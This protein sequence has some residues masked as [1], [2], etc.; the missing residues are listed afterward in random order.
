MRKPSS[1]TT[2]MDCIRVELAPARSSAPLRRA[3]SAVVPTHRAWARISKIMRGWPVMP[4]AAMASEP[5]VPT[6]MVSTEPMMAMSAP[7]TVAGQAMER[8]SLYSSI[9]VG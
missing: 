6:I 7:S 5:R 4:T 8:F 1:V 9:S 2:N 3:T